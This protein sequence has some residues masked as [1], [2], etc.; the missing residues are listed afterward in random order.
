MSK[1]S[2]EQLD[3]PYP[4][5]RH[6]KKRVLPII[7]F[8]TALIGIIMAL[9]SQW[10]TESIYLQISE[11]RSI[12]ISTALNNTNKHAWEQLQQSS[13]PKQFLFSE[14]GQALLQA[15]RNEVSELGL[16]HLKIYGPNAITLYSSNEEKIGEFGKSEGYLKAAQGKRTLV[17]KTTPDNQHLYELYVKVPNNPNNIVMELYEP[18]DYLDTLTQ[19][20]IIPAALLP[21]LLLALITWIMMKLANKA[22]SDI[23]YRNN[24]VLE[25]KEKLQK[26]VS[27]EAANSLKTSIGQGAVKSRRIKVTIL[28]SDIRGFTSFCENEDPQTVVSFLN[29]S[30]GIV[31]EAINKEKGDVD[32]IIGDAIFGFFQGKHSEQRAL[33][34]AIAAIIKT[35]HRQFPRKIGIG[36]YTGDVI[37]GTIGAD[38]RMDFTMI[39]DSVNIASRLCSK[40]HEGN[41]IIDKTSFERCHYTQQYHTQKITVKGRENALS[42]IKIQPQ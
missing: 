41:I 26:L 32:K 16:S 11:R 8:L 35:S 3:R 23:T 4:L 7:I 12:S 38:S 37:I 28:F 40:A 33:N 20:T 1:I 39:G 10:I 36:I 21:M 5:T 18:I 34:A 24:L 31:I 2:T 22:Q 19:Q 6:F 25:Y 14:K 15:I 29:D 27:K 13:N 17:D 42:I 9:S 30:L